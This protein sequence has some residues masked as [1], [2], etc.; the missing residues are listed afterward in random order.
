MYH[1]L[2]KRASTIIFR[3]HYQQLIYHIDVPWTVDIIMSLQ[4]FQKINMTKTYRKAQTLP[5]D[6]YLKLNG[7]EQA[8]IFCLVTRH[9]LW[10]HMYTELRIGNSTLC[11]CVRALQT[12]KHILQNCTSYERDTERTVPDP[13]KTSKK[14]FHTW[15]TDKETVHV[16]Q[17]T[18]LDIDGKVFAKKRIKKLIS[19]MAPFE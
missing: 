15:T 17:E 7:K 12:V 11:T 10:N 3:Q 8:I 19:I 9:Q 18:E 13:L 5:H 1:F 6:D 2:L 16:I 4:M 14:W